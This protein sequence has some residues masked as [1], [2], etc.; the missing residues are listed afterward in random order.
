MVKCDTS[1]RKNISKKKVFLSEKYLLMTFL[2]YFI[3]ILMIWLV[4]LKD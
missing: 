1:L 4:K 2:S 3:L